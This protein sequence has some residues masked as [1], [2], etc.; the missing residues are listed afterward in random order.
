M[1]KLTK[2]AVDAAGPTNAP[3]QTFVWDSEIRGFGLRIT[4]KGRK[5]FAFQ[6][7]AFEGHARH[8][9]RVTNVVVAESPGLL[10]GSEWESGVRRAIA[11]G[12]IGFVSSQA[13]T[14]K[15][16]RQVS[17][18]SRPKRPASRTIQ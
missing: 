3:K 6:F 5:T 9:P 2:R 12:D 8:V 15:A 17:G 18:P 14:R 4:A 1:P 7:G 11:L 13:A 10:N 16:G